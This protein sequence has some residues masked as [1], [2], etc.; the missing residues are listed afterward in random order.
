MAM[1]LS[2]TTLSHIPTISNSK[3]IRVRNVYHHN[4]IAKTTLPLGCT[5][6]WQHFPL[7]SST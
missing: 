7:A 5:S 6:F 1:K 2:A 3:K 4:I